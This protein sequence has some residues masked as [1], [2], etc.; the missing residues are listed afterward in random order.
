MK[1]KDTTAATTFA[2]SCPQATTSTRS[3]STRAGTRTTARAA[4]PAARTSRWSCRAGGADGH[5]HLQRTP[6]RKSSDSINNPTEPGIDGDIWWDGLRHDSRDPLYRTPFG[7]V[8]KG[9]EVRLRFR[10]TAGD[11]EGVGVRV[12]DLF[13]GGA[14]TYRMTK[15]GD[16]ARRRRDRGATISGRSR[17]PHRIS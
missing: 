5:L 9:T 3:P 13:G 17:S 12:A 10:T 7:A 16:R 11:V 8:T 1:D 2:G 4:H 14:S 15:V 6:P